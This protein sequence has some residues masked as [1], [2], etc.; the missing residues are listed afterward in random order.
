[1]AKFL[2]LP[3]AISRHIHDGDSVAT[4]G[5]HADSGRDD[6]APTDAVVTLATSAV[7]SKAIGPMTSLMPQRA[8]MLCAISV[9]WTMSD[10][11]PLVI[12]P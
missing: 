4:I 9:S 3:D 11:A 10:S 5:M 6:S 12:V 2:S 1:M 8:T 7:P